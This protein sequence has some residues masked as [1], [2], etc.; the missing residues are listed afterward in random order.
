VV[1]SVRPSIALLVFGVTA[2][3]ASCDSPAE[4]SA[5]E[6]EAGGVLVQTRVRDDRQFFF[7]QNFSEREQVLA[8]LHAGL[9]DLL[10]GGD[11]GRAVR[12]PPW[13]ST[14]LSNRAT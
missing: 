4:R 5:P 8:E 12:L 7:V 6:S 13:S 11:V 2:V 14:V 10:T 1:S 9:V 3:A